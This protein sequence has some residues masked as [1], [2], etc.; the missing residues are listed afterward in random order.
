[1]LKRDWCIKSLAGLLFVAALAV[2]NIQPIRAQTGPAT[3]TIILH[4]G[5]LLTVD[6]DFSVAEAVAVAGNRIIAVGTN[7]EVLPLAG[8]D[9]IL[10]D[11]KGRTVVPG[12]IDTHINNWN[13]PGP[14]RAPL[15]ADDY[16]DMHLDWRAV[17]SKEDV[18]A[19]IRQ[20]I[21]RHN[22]PAGRWL[23]F[24]NEPRSV[25]HNKILLDD[26]DRYDL[27]EVIPD[28]PAVLT[29]GLPAENMIFVN[30]KAIDQ[31]WGDYGDF[32]GR[33][34]RYWLGNDGQPD[35]HLEAPATRIIL[36]RYLPRAT[37]EV[38]APGY[39]N[40]MEELNAQGITT[41]SNKMLLHGIEAYRQL[42][43]SGE[44]TVRLAYGLGW[45]YF[46]NITD[47]RELEQFQGQ[48]GS[49]TD[50]IWMNSVAPSS[51]DGSG[52]RACTNQKRSEAY[53]EL[54]TWFPTGQCLT[55]DEY[56]GGSGRAAPI[57]GNY[58]EEWI[59]AMGD[60]GLRLANDHVAG[61]R[62]VAN[63]LTMI[64]EIQQQHGPDATRDWAFD[65]CT[66]M[67]PD[68]IGRAVR[69]GVSFSCAPKYILG[70]A[71]AS[72]A[73]GNEMANTFIVPIKSMIDAGAKVAYES[74]TGAYIWADLQLMITRQ[75]AQGRVWGPQERVDR[76]TA[77][78]TA[79][80]WAADYV[81]KGDRLGSITVG[82]L[83][84][85][86]VLDK[87]YMAIPEEALG[88]IKPLMTMVDGRIVF[89]HND[90]SAEYNL[91]PEGAV[92]STYE[93]LTERRGGASARSGEGLR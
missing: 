66:F 21:E 76:A 58:F 88:G 90:F 65:H 3:A 56:R 63:L 60:Y 6:E 73:Y 78:R 7:E 15:P 47:P 10:L 68:D 42:E 30:S 77:L 34:G 22:P 82:K 24:H 89:V 41:I 4:H 71:S 17:V 91:R 26:M 75:D 69:L 84:D 43:R 27:D 57:S 33:Y 2:Q 16:W 48:I 44:Q 92:I 72:L 81:L 59:M 40:V 5:N 64:E 23:L 86:V 14:Y 9:T 8:P 79:S 50:M 18:L 67:N 32:I 93:D 37:P 62:T 83:A 46:G 1:M 61:D 52:T 80:Q 36:N 74:G 31:V 35:G 38:M 53:G 25:A 55:D 51:I 45:E 70:G 87:D 28:N 49:G 54:N 19:Q 20:L 85:M 29:M 39:R 11:L 13:D 12:M